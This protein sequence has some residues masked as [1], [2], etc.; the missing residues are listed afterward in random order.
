MELLSTRDNLPNSSKGGRSQEL[1]KD[2]NHG[3]NK[4]SGSTIYSIFHPDPI[5]M[6]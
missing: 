2:V 1:H 5:K 6:L 4:V 3:D